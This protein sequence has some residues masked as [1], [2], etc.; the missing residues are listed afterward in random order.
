MRLSSPFGIDGEEAE[1][2]DRETLSG[3]R[4]ATSV[5]TMP[6]N[7]ELSSTSQPLSQATVRYGKVFHT[8]TVASLSSGIERKEGFPKPESGD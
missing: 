6:S 8:T 1:A 5:V 2:L 7:R 3:A 4:F